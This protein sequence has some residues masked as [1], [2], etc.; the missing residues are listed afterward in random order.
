MNGEKVFQAITDLEDRYIEEAICYAPGN[1]AGAPG[2]IVHMKKKRIITLALAAALLLALGVGAYAANAAVASPQAAEKVAREQLEELKRM[3]ILAQNVIFEGSA[4]EIFE[5]EEA[6]GDAYWYSRLFPH[7]Y[8]VQWYGEGKFSGELRVDTRSG[9]ILYAV[10]CAW[11][12][13]GNETNLCKH[14]EDIIPDDLTVD[15]FCGLLAEYRG[16]SGYR[17][18]DTTDM[19]YGDFPAI[20]GS[21][22]M[23]DVPRIAP[24]NYYLTVFFEGDQ[25][26]AP[27]YISLNIFEDC[28]RLSFGDG[29]A[30]G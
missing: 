27:M 22:L 18:A 25:E 11:P 30:V 16:F 13:V 29:H 28:V 6:Q 9:K 2:R 17:I 26:G 19:I 10:I 20:D 21:V 24:M 23:K 7:N 8:Q 12:D 4:T 15:R 14:A 5:N 3:G 1:A